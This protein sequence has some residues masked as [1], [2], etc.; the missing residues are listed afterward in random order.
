MREITNAHVSVL[1]LNF[2]T[3]WVTDECQ[4]LDDDDDK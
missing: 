2:A 3:K 4:C 1:L